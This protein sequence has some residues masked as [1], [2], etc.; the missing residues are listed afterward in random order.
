MGNSRTLALG[1]IPTAISDTAP[2]DCATD[3]WEPIQDPR[4]D[5][6]HSEAMVRI[7]RGVT[8]GARGGEDGQE[9]RE[10]T[11]KEESF[12]YI[13]DGERFIIQSTGCNVIL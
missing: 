4:A 5:A 8:T 13:R 6:L 10:E 12:F 1:S 11:G 2:S 3:K 9:D 7:W